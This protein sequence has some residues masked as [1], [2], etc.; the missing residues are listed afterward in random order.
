MKLWPVLAA[1]CTSIVP[2]VAAAQD[3]FPGFKSNAEIKAEE[4]ARDG[5][6]AATPTE[7]VARVEMSAMDV[8]PGQALDMRVTVLVPTYMPSPP[9]FPTFDQ[10]NLMISLP[11]G[12][13]GPVTERVG[14]SNWSG[15][16]RRYK[17]TPMVAG[18][19]GIPSLEIT[20]TWADPETNAPVE[21]TLS[22]AAQSFAAT[23]PDGS[24]SLDPFIAAETLSLT[25]TVEGSAEALEPGDTL[26]R[27]IT[28]EITGSSA[29]LLPALAPTGALPGLAAYPDSPTVQDREN[30]GKTVGTR[31]ERTVYLAESGAQSSLPVIKLRWFNTNTGQ[32]ETTS[33]EAIPYNVDGPI[34]RSVADSDRA[35]LIYMGFAV[36]LGTLA[37]IGLIRHRAR[38]RDTS[39]P[40]PTEASLFRDLM[41]TVKARD[42]HNL[43]GALDRWAAMTQGPDPRRHTD[44]QLALTKIGAAAYGP[45][46]SEPE[47][48]W[49]ALA[50]A[51]SA[52]RHSGTLTRAAQHLP[53]LNPTGSA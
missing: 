25:Q 38:K 53:A 50:T 13:S 27:N 18:N 10:P 33:V 48:A 3:P 47:A 45:Q 44:V 2:D 5:S 31:S 9:V 49:A 42:L 52:A 16:S 35:T 17:V 30:R 46:D 6:E 4:D 1:L 28:A 24:E 34:L 43:Y 40:P 20:V 15:V 8:V 11:E 32:I 22:L 12:G 39:P 21:T 26:T 36:L 29:I 7:P 23:V 41:H 51:L 37:A 14:A 19:F